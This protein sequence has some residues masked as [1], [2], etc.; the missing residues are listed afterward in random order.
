[1]FASSRKSRDAVAPPLVVKGVWLA[2]DT[3]TDVASVAVA[4]PGTPAVIEVEVGPRRQA[5]RLVPMIDAALHRAGHG[6]DELAGVAVADGPGSFTGLRIGWAAA[7]G[8]VHARGLP[9][10]YAPS[11]LALAFA[12]W[13]AAGAPAGAPVAVCYDALRGHVFGAMYAFRPLV[14]E[15]VVAPGVMTVAAFARVAPRRPALVAGDGVHR[16][17]EEI[18]TWAGRV[19]ARQPV[20]AAGALLEIA[21]WAGGLAPLRDYALAEPTYGRVAEAQA[22][23]EA[24]HGRPLPDPF[25][26]SG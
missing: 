25:R 26:H 7:K 1:M 8:L 21:G 24:R 6:R 22:R 4:V 10:W 23:W 5:A 19:P 12:T 20:P 11:L 13:R 3:A 9:L 14:V 17:A 18:Y 2:L 16:Y 15:T